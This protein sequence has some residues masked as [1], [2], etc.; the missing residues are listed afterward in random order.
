MILRSS[1]PSPFGRKV[2]IAAHL[3]GIIDQ[4][5]IVRTDTTADDDP[6]RGLN[7]L[8]K[9]PALELDDGRVLYD[10]R[11]IIEY[12][13]H[14]TGGGML[15]PVDPVERFD[16]LTGQ[17]L[18]DG[19]MDAALLQIYEVRMR[20]ESERS[21]KWLALQA[22]KVKRA[23]A[24]LEAAPPPAVPNV[25]SVATACALGYLDLRFEGAW[26]KDHP[27][28]VQWLDAFAATTPAFGATRAH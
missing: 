9:I 17:A 22:G 18:A 16:A 12:L 24:H 26:R 19:L 27:T 25:F 28:L 6:I 3:L 2:K 7:P 10:S 8:G 15:I 14:L 5:E 4:I 23:L 13:D 20:D 11:V 21:A 1:P